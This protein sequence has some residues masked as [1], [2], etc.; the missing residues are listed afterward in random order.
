MGLMLCPSR[1]LLYH[2]SMEITHPS[3]SGACAIS[4]ALARFSSSGTD[5]LL[6][7][8]AIVVP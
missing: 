3:S 6:G 5:R 4:R 8:L 2:R 7:M 1:R